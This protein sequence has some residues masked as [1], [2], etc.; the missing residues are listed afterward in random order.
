MVLGGA[1]AGVKGEVAAGSQTIDD[2]IRNRIADE[3]REGINNVRHGNEYA[4][5]SNEQ[6]SQIIAKFINDR[7]M[8][9]EHA[10]VKTMARQDDL[11]PPNLHIPGKGAPESSVIKP[12]DLDE[13][14]VT[15]P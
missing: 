15:V 2:A 8:Y 7:E 4:H 11:I 1:K 5:L 9:Y 13:K 12:N 6:K 10:S 14:T 3:M